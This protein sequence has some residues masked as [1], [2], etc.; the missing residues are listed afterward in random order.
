MNTNISTTCSSFDI[1]DLP[2]EIDTNFPFNKEELE[3]LDVGFLN[4]NLINNENSYIITSNENIVFENN[5]LHIESDT[6]IQLQHLTTISNTTSNVQEMSNQTNKI[7]YKY[8]EPSTSTNIQELSRSHT[9]SSPNSMWNKHFSWP[10]EDKINPKL[11]RKRPIVPYAITIKIWIDIQV[12]K[13]NLKEE[14]ESLI[15][16]KRNARVLKKLRFKT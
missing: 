4:R 7:Q 8:Q 1:L 2:V 11:K 6:D 5:L 13:E 15:E 9:D 12:E 14:K 10:K 16:E 3:S